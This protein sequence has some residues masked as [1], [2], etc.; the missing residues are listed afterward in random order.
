MPT[1]AIR[2]KRHWYEPRLPHAVFLNSYYVGMLKDDQLRGEVKG[3]L[4]PCRGMD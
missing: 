2:H 1:L 4:H 3:V